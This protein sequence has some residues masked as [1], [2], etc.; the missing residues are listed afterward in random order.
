MFTYSINENISLKILLNSDVNDLFELIEYNRKHLSEVYPWALEINST[1]DVKTIIANQIKRFTK[2]KGIYAGITYQDKLAGMISI[3]NIDTV[4]S[5]ASLDVWITRKLGR[6][7]IATDTLWTM[8]Q[9]CFSTMELNRL[10]IRTPVDNRN[11]RD[12]CLKVGYK[13]EAFL[14]DQVKLNGEFSDIVV[15][16]RLYRDWISG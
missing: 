1:E 14:A 11:G 15:Y 10:E 9:Y 8:T 16:S 3:D 13:E 2:N 6:Q 4:N 5:S 12:L 7:Q